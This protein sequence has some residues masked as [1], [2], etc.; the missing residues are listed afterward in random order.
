MEGF[1][2]I[3]PRCSWTPQ[4]DQ[5]R[6]RQCYDWML[7]KRCEQHGQNE[8]CSVCLWINWEFGNCA[9]VCCLRTVCSL[10][11][12]RD[13]KHICFFFFKYVWAGTKRPA[14]VKT[15]NIC[16]HVKKTPTLLNPAQHKLP[17][18]F[19]SSLTHLILVGK[20]WGRKSTVTIA[21]SQIFL[22]WNANP[23]STFSFSSLL[24]NGGFCISYKDDV[25]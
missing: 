8:F 7:A 11:Y 13:Y 10:L 16:L 24:L 22:L 20:N 6:T 21:W 4:R 9:N 25:Q 15:S 17:V 5:I 19:L 23:I 2:Q 1:I 3:I 14:S 18:C 12:V